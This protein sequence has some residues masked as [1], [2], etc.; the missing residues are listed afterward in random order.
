M[1]GSEGINA[2]PRLGA[3]NK[4]NIWVAGLERYCG[5]RL[6]FCLCGD[7]LGDTVCGC[8]CVCLLAVRVLMSVCACVSVW[9]TADP[10]QQQCQQLHQ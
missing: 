1:Q 5:A 7:A 8:V 4:A 9:A 10:Q 2:L 6:V 3:A